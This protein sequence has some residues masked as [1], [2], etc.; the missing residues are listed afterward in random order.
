MKIYKSIKFYENTKIYQY[1]SQIE[2]ELQ[3][4]LQIFLENKKVY[5]NKSQIILEKQLEIQLEEELLKNKILKKSLSKRLESIQKNEIKRIKE[6]ENIKLQKDI[7]LQEELKKKLNNNEIIIRTV[8]IIFFDYYKK[9]HIYK[10]NSD[11]ELK[12]LLDNE[13][14][15]NKR[16]FIENI[17]NNSKTLLK[18]FVRESN[19]EEQY[20]SLF[21]KNILFTF[22]N[23]ISD[24]KDVLYEI[25]RIINE[26]N[27]F[28]K[29][30]F[31]IITFGY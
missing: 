19:I 13:I 28:N 24:K 15:Y 23:V 12:S 2:K 27:R 14:E 6:L 9:Q 10:I 7:K 25:N 4:E 8:T 18:Y 11:D 5:E 26:R 21:E 31:I 30:T 22:E 17:N 1:Q 29:N 20:S 3:V 16:I